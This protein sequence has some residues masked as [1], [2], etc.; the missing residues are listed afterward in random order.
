MSNNKGLV[1]DYRI[2]L[3]AALQDN[4]VYNMLLKYE[5]QVDFRT[6][7]ISFPT[8]RRALTQALERKGADPEAAFEVLTGLMKIV[9]PINAPLYEVF[10]PPARERVGAGDSRLWPVVAV[11]LLFESPIWTHDEDFF[12]TGI[13]VWKTDTIELYLKKS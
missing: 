2:L 11:A 1:L 10:G 9:E 3:E 8:V 6:P 7:D 5:N 4:P 13:A 12:G